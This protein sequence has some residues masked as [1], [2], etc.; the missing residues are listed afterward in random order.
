MTSHFL[1][2]LFLG[3]DDLQKM[4]LFEERCVDGYLREKDT[5][6]HA[7]QEEKIRVI[8]DRCDYFLN[9]YKRQGKGNLA[10]S[11]YTVY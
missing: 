6:L 2:E 11:I 1:V 8:G 3:R 10:I 9:N 4:S 7:T 5:L